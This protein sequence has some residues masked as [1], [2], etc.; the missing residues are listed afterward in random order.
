MKLILLGAPGAG[1]GTQAEILS[2]ELHIPTVSTGNIIRSAIQEKT[3]LGL[4]AKAFV[5][6]GGLVP[7]GIVVGMLQEYLSQNNYTDGY[8]L[9]GF[10]RTIQQAKTLE[11][12]GIRIERVVY[13]QADCETIQNRLAQ[14]KVCRD[15]GNSYHL[16]NKPPLK[17]GVCDSCGGPLITRKDDQP[18][19]ILERLK[20]YADTTEQLI[21][22]YAQQ[23]ILL[24]IDGKNSMEQITSEIL[25]HL[26]AQ[27]S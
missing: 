27:P 13:L 25:T 18:E 17:N 8:I 21:E 20:V 1:K 11:D 23:G 10:P 12:M 19:T 15:C 26:C 14:R 7:D 22:F 2:K 9:D 24:T 6:S 4:E 5:E 16:T 3:P